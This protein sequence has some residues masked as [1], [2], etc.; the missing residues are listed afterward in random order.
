[1]MAFVHVRAEGD[2]F[3]GAFGGDECVFDGIPQLIEVDDVRLVDVERSEGC[4]RYKKIVDASE[5]FSFALPRT[6]GAACLR[7]VDP[8]EVAAFRMGL[9]F[10]G[11]NEGGGIH[12]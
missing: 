10:E 12:L 2:A 9:E 1:M 11:F 6:N 3:D 8:A 4:V 7:S 5:R